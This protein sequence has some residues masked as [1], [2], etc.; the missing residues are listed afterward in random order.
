MAI[1]TMIERL[2][3]LLNGGLSGQIIRYGITGGAVTALQEAIYWSL[4]GPAHVDP[5]IANFMG[6]IAAVVSGYFAHGRFSFRGHGVREKPVARALR[7]WAVS[8]VSLALNA[9]W[10][11][12]FVTHG[13]LPVWSPIPFK[14]V[15]TPGL[16]FLLNRQWVF[17]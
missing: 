11:W 15:V 3:G 7:F 13:H 10:V 14:A 4:A 8:L 9:F 5:Q 2:R 17:R 1:G 6:Y 16:V 12:L